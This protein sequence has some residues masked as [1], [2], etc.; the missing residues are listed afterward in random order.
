MSNFQ[1]PRARKKIHIDTDIGGDPDDLC[2][3]ALVL[4]SPVEIAGIT[5]CTEQQGRRAGYVHEALRLVGRPG[6]PVAAGAE[7]GVEGLRVTPGIPDEHDYWGGPV[8]PVPGPV[9]TAIDLL[10]ASIEAGATIVA[11]GPYTN[12]A[13]LETRR[14]GRL[15]QAE[16][17]LMGGCVGPM[18]AGL[19]EWG[20]R[21]DWNMHLDAAA[22]EIMFRSSTPLIV[23][24]NV[25]L[26]VHLR[27]R[28]LA[29]MRADG[30][31]AV[32]MAR[33]AVAVAREYDNKKLGRTHAGLP[34]DLLNFQHDP[35]ACA[36]ALGWPGVA[37][38]EL[39][40]RLDTDD[41]YPVLRAD[42]G[43]VR[44]RIVTGVDAER[45]ENFWL[46]LVTK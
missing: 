25:T 31:L 38:E 19:P 11:I 1:K 43:G 15:A 46:D 13:L 16:L 41:G 26:K 7:D 45:F 36:V 29:R 17:V 24:I 2:A 33:Q 14:P 28:H 3:L 20:P 40:L 5:T 44:H 42:D 10:D 9:D 22:T 12:L 30:P 39:R 18:A 35:L 8:A 21:E 34:D 4:A 6:V 27:E 37:I 32:L 23:P